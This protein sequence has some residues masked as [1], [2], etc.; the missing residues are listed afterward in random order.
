MK[1]RLLTIFND[2]CM[3]EYL[4]IIQNEALKYCIDNNIDCS[5]IMI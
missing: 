1:K 2:I 5:H 3:V 4:W